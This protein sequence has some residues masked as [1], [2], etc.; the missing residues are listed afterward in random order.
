[1]AKIKRKL[2]HTASWSNVLKYHGIDEDAVLDA[3]DNMM[4]T[5]LAYRRGLCSAF[6][7]PLAGREGKVTLS[8]YHEIPALLTRLGMPNSKRYNGFYWPRNETGYNQRLMFLA[9]LLAWL[10]DK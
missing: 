2:A 7:T 1:M 6:A 9:F 5:Y 3:I 10:E 8:S 4:N